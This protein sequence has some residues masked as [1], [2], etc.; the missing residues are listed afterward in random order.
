MCKNSNSIQQS[1]EENDD[2]DNEKIYHIQTDSSNQPPP[3]LPNKNLKHRHQ[4]SKRDNK[5]IDE[6]PDDFRMQISDFYDNIQDNFNKIKD[7]LTKS[8][9]PKSRWMKIL[10]DRKI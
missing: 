3:P 8:T 5:P 10:K 1:K 9:T 4:D 2:K 7:D 6:K